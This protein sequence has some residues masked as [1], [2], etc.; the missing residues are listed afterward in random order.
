MVSCMHAISMYWF[1]NVVTRSG[2]LIGPCSGDKHLNH[3]VFWM[4][5]YIYIYIIEW[6]WVWGINTIIAKC[7]INKVSYSQFRIWGFICLFHHTDCHNEHLT[8]LD[9]RTTYTPLICRK[10]LTYPFNQPLTV[11]TKTHRIDEKTN[12]LE[13]IYFSV[14][15]S[16]RPSVNR[17]HSSQGLW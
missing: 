13:L 10:T 6:H 5:I 4:F 15:I 12:V 9:N 11:L 17:V 2:G 8:V 14:E 16:C 7:E 1:Y 3:N